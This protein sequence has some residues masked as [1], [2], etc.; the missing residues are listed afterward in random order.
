[1]LSKKTIIFS[2]LCVI[3]ITVAIVVFQK[4]NTSKEQHRQ[5]KAV[6]VTEQTNISPN[7]KYGGTLVIGTSNPP[8]SINPVYAQNSV[9][10][11]LVDILFDGLIRVDQHGKEVHLLAHRWEISDDGLEYI[12]YLRKDVAFHDGVPLTA[13]DVKFTYDLYRSKDVQSF[14]Y[15]SLS[16]IQDITVLDEW[17]I[18]FSLKRKN[19]FFLRRLKAPIIPQHVYGGKDL[20]KADFHI[21]PI[22]TGMYRF[23]SWDK[24]TNQIELAV[25]DAYFDGRA[26]IERIVVKT[27]PSIS[28]LWAAILRGEVDVISFLSYGDFQVLKADPTFKTCQAH[29]N[30]YSAIYFNPDAQ[31]LSDPEVRKAIS[32]SIDRNTLVEYLSQGGQPRYLPLLGDIGEKQPA[33]PYRYDPLKAKLAL[34]H[35]GWSDTDGDGILEKGVQEFELR[36]LVYQRDDS[37]CRLALLLRQ[38]LS[39]VGVKLTIELF[40]G[41]EVLAPDFDKQSRANAWLR[42]FMGGEEEQRTFDALSTWTSSSSLFGQV[43][44]Y[45]HPEIDRI[46]D[47]VSQAE[48]AVRKQ[49]FRQ[50]NDILL[51][52][53]PLTCLFCFEEFHAVSARIKNLQSSLC[54]ADYP[55]VIK[56][57]YIPKSSNTVDSAK[58]E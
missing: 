7:D 24:T 45:H 41:E 55:Y 16:L 53:H 11:T 1:M 19:V 5:S 57:W 49:L 28:H 17:T 38:Q 14:H 22:G 13:A 25:H 12:F 48:P 44:K 6:E 51:E 2:L 9:S 31:I 23:R 27:Y 42:Y 21:Q 29:S 39:E 56:E 43:W 47:A 18:K 50:A 58:Y 4:Y 32:M 52:D 20:R 35:R 10:A 46:Y 15:N 37:L 8:L 54:G 36:L 33:T 40:D 3:L 34:M 30:Y 26:N